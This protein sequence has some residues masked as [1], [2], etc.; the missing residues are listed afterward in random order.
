MHCIPIQQISLRE[1]FL[2]F[3]MNKSYKEGPN[4]SSINIIEFFVLPVVIIFGMP[5]SLNKY[6]L[7]ASSS[8]YNS[9]FERDSIFII[10]GLEFEIHSP[11]YILNK[12]VLPILFFILYFLKRILFKFSSFWFSFSF[13]S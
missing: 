1:N 9:S 3:S 10:T 11:S 12:D 2:L 8:K 5:K 13:I 6:K 7:R 4:F